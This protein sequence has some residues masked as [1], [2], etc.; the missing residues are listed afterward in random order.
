MKRLKIYVLAILACCMLF[1]IGTNAQAYKN[2]ALTYKIII[3]YDDHTVVGY[4]K[5]VSGKVIAKADKYYY[6]FSGKNVEV[7][8]G[9]YSGKLLN[10]SYADYYQNKQL[11]ESGWYAAG[12]K[13]GQWKAWSEQGALLND[14]QWI[15]G[16]K[17]GVYHRYDAQGKVIETGTFNGGSVVPPDTSR[18]TKFF[19]KIFKPNKEKSR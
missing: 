6:W 8:Q 4:T 13:T 2:N 14:Y 15:N 7:T 5:P 10:G 17:A 12:L 16:V 9:G 11:K 1:T 3:N 18:V 19:R